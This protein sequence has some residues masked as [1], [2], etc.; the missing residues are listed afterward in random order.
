MAAHHPADQVALAKAEPVD[1]QE[2]RG[3]LAQ[4]ALGVA[5]LP[6]GAPVA[7]RDAAVEHPSGDQHRQAGRHQRQ[8]QRGQHRPGAQ[9]APLARMGQRDAG[10]QHRPGQTA[11]ATAGVQHREQLGHRRSD[12]AQHQHRIGPEGHIGVPVQHGMDEG[13]RLLHV[14]GGGSP[15]L[16]PVRSIGIPGPNL[17]PACRIRI[18]PELSRQRQ[19][20]PAG[21]FYTATPAP[22]A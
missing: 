10:A 16:V 12:A 15:A 5:H 9:M 3:I 19:D 13:E 1:R 17:T 18:N 7:A 8:R 11:A 22:D 21:D 6:A 20:R 2:A 4:L 14:V